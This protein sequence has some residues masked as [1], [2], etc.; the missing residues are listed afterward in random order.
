MR[1]RT[2]VVVGAGH[3]GLVAA[4]LAA[5]AG[6]SVT[7]LERADHPGGATVGAAVFEGHPI[8]LSQYSY[9]VSLFPADLIDRLGIK[10]P[11]APRSVASYTPVHRGGVPRGLLVEREPGPATRESFRA[12]TGSDAEFDSWQRFYAELRAMAQA[13]APLLTGPLRSRS[14]VRAAVIAAAGEQ[15]WRDVVEEPI[16]QAI[17]RRFADDTVR[18][19]VA[20]DALIGTHASLFDGSLLANRCFLY[21]LVGRGTGEWLVP[22]GGMGSLADGLVTRALELGVQIR[23][24]T[25]VWRAEED[26]AGVTVEYRGG[27]GIGERRAEVLL[28][29]VAP[30]TVE[31]WLGRA[32]APPEGAQLKVN[33]LLS[34]LPWLASGDDPAVVFAGTTHLAEGF[35]ELQRA[36]AESAAG[37]LPDPLPCEIYCH[38]LADPSIMAGRPG[39]TLTLFALHTPASL[40]RADPEAAR[41][42]ALTGALASLQRQLAEPLEGC[43]A[44]DAHGRPCVQ[45][46]SPLDLQESVGMPGGHIFHGD[47]A[48]PWRA[49]DE[50]AD[51]PAQRYGV[52][53][54]GCERILLAGAGTRRGGGVSGLGGLA[55]VQALGA[56]DAGRASWR[57]IRR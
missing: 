28:A 4:I 53:V 9:L 5:Q 43:L 38:S 29:A 55:A 14:E 2:A 11:L 22:V 24:G 30:A 48:W 10:L 16:G 3:N 13:V 25:E 15:I 34:R 46:A 47:L 39:H 20:T 56:G 21:H 45:A 44:L 19:V 6:W 23:C 40:F 49:D 32:A 12:L 7:V 17:A 18:G 37:R 35:D 51:T 26:A 54:A 42:A 8:R 1:E 31:T 50:A 41:Q 27:D 57:G 52:E 36:F 33:M